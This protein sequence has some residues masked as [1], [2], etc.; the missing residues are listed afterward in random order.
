[1]PARPGSD[2]TQCVMGSEHR[3][4]ITALNT[5]LIDLRKEVRA[6]IAEI[7][8]KL[9]GRP[10]WGVALVI[11]LLSSACVSMLLLLLKRTGG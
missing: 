1:M 2:E 10:T 11:T 6:D 8:N 7:K 9:L 3:I 4:M 5:A